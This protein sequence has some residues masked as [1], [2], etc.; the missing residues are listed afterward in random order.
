M[1]SLVI[2]SPLLTELDA[3]STLQMRSKAY[4]GYDAEFIRACKEEL[5][6]RPEHLTE[7]AVV[8]ADLDGRPAGVAQVGPYGQDADLLA[9][10]VDPP[11]IGKGLGRALFDWCLSAARDISQTR[12]LIDAEPGAAAFY[13]H[14]GARRIGTRPSGSIPGRML[15][16]YEIPLR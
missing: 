11:F 5:T 3:L 13:E 4:W 6:L 2:R 12:L 15:P 10:F 8:V 7:T 9:L 14:M 1:T 16:L